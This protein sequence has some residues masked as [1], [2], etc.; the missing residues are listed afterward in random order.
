MS[1]TLRWALIGV[2]TIARQRMV[3]AIRAADGEIVAVQSGNAERA[4]NFA[5]E[6]GL[7]QA[8][9]DISATLRNAEAVYISSTNDQH[10]AHV[11]AAVAAGCHVLCEK[12]LSTTL[13]AARTMI[14]AAQAKGLVLAVNHH[15]R[16]NA[17]HRAIRKH[18]EDG[19]IGA[20]RAVTISN[21]GWLPEALRGW[22]LDGDGAG[23]ALDKTV[24]DVDLLR[25]LLGSN[26]VAVT[27]STAGPANRPEQAIMGTLEFADGVLAQ[28]H[29][30]FNAPHAQTRLEVIGD[31]GRL[32]AEDCLSGRPAGT[33][34]LLTAEGTRAI[35]VSH[36][37]PYAAVISDFHRALATG[38]APAV[39]GS[40]G[41]IALA[42]ALAA[43]SASRSGKKTT[44]ER[45]N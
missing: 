10:H 43:I 29:D 13:E 38:T 15:L 9:T 37:D 3:G 30:D 35:P 25:F 17:V 5:A 4:R 20:I 36:T 24:H 7:P 19:S 16:H 22:R 28:F 18:I 12:P 21:A 34:R 32:V 44:L 40:D 42:A 27:A 1:N 11:L 8:E 31:G 2:S 14:A 41:A 33:L 6:F 26:P 39:T 23:I 45:I